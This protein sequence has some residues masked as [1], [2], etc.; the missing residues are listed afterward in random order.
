MFHTDTALFCP[1]PDIRRVP[2]TAELYDL[3]GFQQLCQR[4]LDGD[5]T[6]IR[7]FGHDF[8]LGDL[9]EMIL[10]DLSHPVWLGKPLGGQQLNPAFKSRYAATR[11]PS[12]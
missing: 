6:D 10:D 8:A 9:A 5:L 11:T 3:T 7:A 4:A 12:I 2:S 1:I